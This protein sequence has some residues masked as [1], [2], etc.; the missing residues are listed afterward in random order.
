VQ[1]NKKDKMVKINIQN[2]NNRKTIRISLIRLFIIELGIHEL[3]GIHIQT[4]IGIGPM[5]MS[6]ILHQWNKW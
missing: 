2:N 1:I 6:F 5:E 3:N 4:G